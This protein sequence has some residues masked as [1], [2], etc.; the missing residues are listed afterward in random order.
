MRLHMRRIIHQRTLVEPGKIQA[1]MTPLIRMQGIILVWASDPVWTH[2]P[3]RVFLVQ[4][5][6]HE[7]LLEPPSKSSAP[8]SFDVMSC[9][10]QAQEL[11][12]RLRAKQ[13]VHART[14]ALV[15]EA[16]HSNRGR[17]CT[18]GSQGPR[19]PHDQKK[20]G[21]EKKQLGNPGSC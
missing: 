19:A 13:T 4:T 17:A 6:I 3:R 15:S 7:L 8:S 10:R 18:R 9:S 2:R 16:L 14:P 1:R 11:A 20:H 12:L 21:I 5:Q